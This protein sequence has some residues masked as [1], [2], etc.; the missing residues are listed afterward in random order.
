MKCPLG[1]FLCLILWEDFLSVVPKFLRCTRCVHWWN[2][3]ATGGKSATKTGAWKFPREH[4][5]FIIKQDMGFSNLRYSF[6]LLTEYDMLQSTGSPCPRTVTGFCR[7]SAFRI[8]KIRGHNCII[9]NFQFRKFLPV[10]SNTAVCIY[11]GCHGLIKCPF[12]HKAGLPPAGMVPGCVLRHRG[13]TRW[14][15]R[16]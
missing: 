9:R 16:S 12:S 13:Y 8:G 14:S 7:C 6:K 4:L 10:K 11:Y 5:T 1:V 15:F 2:S 3:G